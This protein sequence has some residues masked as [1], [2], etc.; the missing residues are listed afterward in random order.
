MARVLTPEEYGFIRILKKKKILQK[1]D[2]NDLPRLTQN[3]GVAVFCGDGDIDASWF[4]RHGI[5]RPHAVKLFGGPLLLFP[6]FRRYNPYFASSVIEN[7]KW[8]MEAKD[9]KALFLYFHYP[10]G[11]AE[12]FGHNLLDV[13]NSIPAVLEEFRRDDF[14][15]PDKIFPFFHVRRINRGGKLEQ[16]TYFFMTDK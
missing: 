1:F 14:F 13:Y 7:I 11:V 2:V 9:T 5:E 3:G 4:H 12:K 8:G 16:N 15:E 6:A 10:C